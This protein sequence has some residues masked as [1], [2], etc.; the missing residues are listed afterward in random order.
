[1]V[2]LVLFYGYDFEIRGSVKFFLRPLSVRKLLECV[3]ASSRLSFAARL[4][5]DIADACR[6]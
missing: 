2:S 1:M 4:I 3:K 5:S 6:L